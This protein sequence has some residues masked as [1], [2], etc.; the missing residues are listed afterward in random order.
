MKRLLIITSISLFPIFTL[1]ILI[2]IKTLIIGNIKDINENFLLICIVVYV[3]SLSIVLNTVLRIKRYA[4]D[5]AE[6]ELYKQTKKL[7]ILI[8]KYN[9]LIV[10]IENAYTMTSKD[11]QNNYNTIIDNLKTTM[12]GLIGTKKVLSFNTPPIITFISNKGEKEDVTIIGIK[13]VDNNVIIIPE[14][15]FGFRELDLF[16]NFKFSEMIHILQEIE[17]IK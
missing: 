13:V 9:N 1:G 12:I 10:N 5:K 2:P 7:D 16:E 4:W 15:S 3:L 11:F 14:L 17:K 6:L 8:S